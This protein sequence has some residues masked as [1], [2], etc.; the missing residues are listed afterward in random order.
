MAVTTDEQTAVEDREGV[1]FRLGDS[2]YCIDIGHVDEI[3][4]RG[5]L[6]PLPNSAPHFEGVM[7]L[8]GETTTIFNPRSYF[9]VERDGDGGDRILILD[10][11]DANVGWVVDG[12][13]RVITFAS[14]H[15]ETQVENGAVEGVL[16]RDDGFIILV[17]PTVVEDT[18][19]AN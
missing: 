10:Q 13:D 17:D 14:E 11:A 4:E 15:V 16:R 5:E 1:V 2:E 8:R 18:T 7:D 9:D 12:V 19:G 6:T 3:V